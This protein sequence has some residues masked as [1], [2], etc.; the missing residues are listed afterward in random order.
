MLFNELPLGLPFYENVKNQNQYRENCQGK[1]PFRIISPNDRI[2]PFQFRKQTNGLDYVTEWW[3]YHSYGG[4]AINLSSNIEDKI[5]TYII[6]GY[7]YIVYEGGGLDFTPGTALDIPSG[8]YY[9]VIKTLSGWY[10]S[11]CFYVPIERFNEDDPESFPYMCLEWWDSSDFDKIY[12][13]DGFKNR[14]YLDTFITGS[15]PEII[16]DGENDGDDNFI[17]TFQ[18]LVIGYNFTISPA[19][20]FLKNALNAMCIHDNVI[21][22]TKGYERIGNI[23]E[24]KVTSEIEQGGCS[25]TLIVDFVQPIYYK[26]GACKSEFSNIECNGFAEIIVLDPGGGGYILQG[27]VPPNVIVKVIDQTDKIIRTESSS[28]IM[29]GIVI[30]ISELVGTTSLRLKAINMGCTYLSDPVDL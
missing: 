15:E 11:E 22:Y 23:K 12:Y 20:D 28:A 5:K 29:A 8:E 26:K 1:C 17:P 25:S 2:I 27:D 9:M 30:A 14:I 21:I 6:D 13:T 16:E 3:L 18:K 19:P 24:I 7:D 10:Y 4:E